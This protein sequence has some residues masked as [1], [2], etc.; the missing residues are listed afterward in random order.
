MSQCQ[1]FFPVRVKNVLRSCQ[2][3][4][5]RGRRGSELYLVKTLWCTYKLAMIGTSWMKL[6]TRK[7]HR[8][9]CVCVCVTFYHAIDWNLRGDIN[10]PIIIKFSF[11]SYKK[12]S[13]GDRKIIPSFCY[14]QNRTLS[15]FCVKRNMLDYYFLHT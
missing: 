6:H 5:G 8:F 11:S 7:N 14:R 1:P 12:V 2:M 9:F 13:M 4:C 15:W 10:F 3:S